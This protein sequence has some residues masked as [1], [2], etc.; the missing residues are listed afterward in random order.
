MA[1]YL[2]HPILLDAHSAPSHDVDSEDEPTR[3]SSGPSVQDREATASPL[4]RQDPGSADDPL[5]GGREEPGS[6]AESSGSYGR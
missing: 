2:Q 3:P 1:G 6:D 4:Q 5:A